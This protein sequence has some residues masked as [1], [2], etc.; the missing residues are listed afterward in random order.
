MNTDHLTCNSNHGENRTDKI[1]SQILG[2]R[3]PRDQKLKLRALNTPYGFR[4]V[5]YSS[6]LEFTRSMRERNLPHSLLY[7]KPNINNITPQKIVLEITDSKAAVPKQI[8]KEIEETPSLRH[9]ESEAQDL[10]PVDMKE[11]LRERDAVP[12]YEVWP[13]KNRFFCKGRLMTGPR[14]DRKT[15]IITWIVTLAIS[16]IFFACGFSLLLGEVTL[17]LPVLSVYLFICTVVFFLLAS[18]TDPGIIPRKQVSELC[19]NNQTSPL[20]TSMKKDGT[21]SSQNTSYQ[22]TL[23]STKRK[24]VSKHHNSKYCQICNITKPNKTTHCK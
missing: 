21:S 7:M 19:G 24:S 11:I 15:N 16:A 6:N 5:T 23:D 18:F 4:D 2:E 20:H 12:L 8:T 17:I 3:G 10:N 22:I 9:A 14:S 13:G 1:A